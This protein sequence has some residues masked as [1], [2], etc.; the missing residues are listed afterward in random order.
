VFFALELI[1]FS[2]RHGRS[3]SFCKWRSASWRCGNEGAWH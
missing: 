2:Q 3:V 1:E